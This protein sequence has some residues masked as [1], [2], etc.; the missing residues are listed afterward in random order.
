[1]CDRGHPADGDRQ[2]GER[3]VALVDGRREPQPESGG[4]RGL[5]RQIQQDTAHQRLVNQLAAEGFSISGVMNCTDQ[6]L[7][8][9]RR[10]AEDAVEPG[11][12]DHVQDGPDAAALP[13]DPDAPGAVRLD[14]R[15]RSGLASR[16]GTAA[17][18]IE[19][20]HP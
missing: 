11:G 19:T 14:L 16:T 5:E 4:R 18:V 7:P 13:A 20:G 9:R 15:R 12:G 17:S 10:R 1:M 6:S 2:P 3:R 8:H